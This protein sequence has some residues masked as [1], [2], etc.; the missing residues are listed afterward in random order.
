MGRKRPGRDNP[1]RQGL[2]SDQEIQGST[3]RSWTQLEQRNK[4]RK[5]Y[6]LASGVLTK[7]GEARTEVSIKYCRRVFEEN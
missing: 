3:P 4:T 5:I 1:R 6:F 2:V 7:E